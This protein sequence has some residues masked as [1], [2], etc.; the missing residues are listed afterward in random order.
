MDDDEAFM[1][2]ADRNPPPAVA[3]L[4]RDG[5]RY[6]RYYG[7]AGDPQSGGLIAAYDAA[8]NQRLWI[9]VVFPNVRNPD[10]EGDAQDVF[11]AEMHFDADGTLR[12]TD[13]RGHHWVVDVKARTSVR[14]H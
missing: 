8:S 5:I 12:V 10:F 7:G 6:E 9:L 13:E 1:P 4:V 3:P 2:Q 14:V 11:V